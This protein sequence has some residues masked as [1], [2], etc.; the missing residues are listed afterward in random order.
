MIEVEV[1]DTIVEF[2]DGTSREVMQD[3]LRRKFMAD[4]KDKLAEGLRDGRTNQG[5]VYR[6]AAFRSNEGVPPATATDAAVSGV[7]AGLSDEAAAA[8]TAPIDMIQRGES[9]DEAYQHNLAA[10]RDRLAKY[11]EANPVTSALAEGAGA[12]AS[13]VNKIPGAIRQAAAYGGLYGFGSSEGDLTDRAVGAAKG[14]GLGGAIGAGLSGA[15]KVGGSVAAPIVRNI[16]AAVNPDRQAAAVIQRDLARDGITPAAARAELEAAQQVGA[17]MTL[18]DIGGRNMMRLGRA[19][20]T[21]KGA[22]SEKYN[23]FLE[24]RRLDAPERVMENVKSALGDADAFYPTLDR[25][26]ARRKEVAAPLYEAAYAKAAPDTPVIRSVLQT[27][28]G[29]TAIRNAQ[30][31][32]ANE[33]VEF[34]ADVRGLDL[35]KRSFDDMIETAS[36]DG[37]NNEV[38]ILVGMRDRL[39][40][41]VDRAVPEYRAAREA[42]SSEAQLQNALERGRELLRPGNAPE[43]VVRELK[44]MTPAER[45]VARLGMAR[46]LRDTFDDP[47]MTAS[48]LSKMIYG[49]RTS[50]IIESIFPSADAA[51]KF[52]ADMMREYLMLKRGQQI[53]GGSNTVDKAVEA[54]DVGLVQDLVGAA[55]GSIGGA[56]SAAQNIGRRV[57][58]GINEKTTDRLADILSSTEPAKQAAIL[59]QIEKMLPPGG[60]QRVIASMG[61]REAAIQRPAIAK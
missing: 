37:K 46:Q 6:A 8:A 19:V 50:K 29:Q 45:E 42:F 1:G 26:V 52:K 54:N 58:G 22:G 9:F 39:V 44:A 20:S 56:I 31:L 35:I 16:R 28:A 24:A 59:D 41:E 51:K 36:R 53:Q 12:A 30:K 47:S 49:N 13:P 15:I 21:S 43:L 14:A 3:A 32:S 7:T 5:E 10:N 40:R 4:A 61:G 57:A 11:R 34:A 48:K 2:P 18:G 17:P 23:A 33:G 25:V 38:R 60:L 27:P 55:R